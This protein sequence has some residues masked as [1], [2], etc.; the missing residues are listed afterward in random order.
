MHYQTRSGL[1][2]TLT[3]AVA[4]IFCSALADV[5]QAGVTLNGDGRVIQVTDIIIPGANY[6]A[7]ITYDASYDDLFTDVGDTPTF[8]GDSATAETVAGIML[9]Q[10]QAAWGS[11]PIQQSII[12]PYALPS[13]DGMT[14]V[15]GSRFRETG[16]INTYTGAP[17]TSSASRGFAKF[18]LTGV[19][20]PTSLV[21]FG[22]LGALGMVGRR[23]RNS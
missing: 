21:L 14:S 17:F 7:D 8:F 22:G 3:T 4:V 6:T 23:R 18:T 5:S 16:D 12:V 19:P 20:E 11:D 15:R 1:L 2:P 13:F 10:S 9:A